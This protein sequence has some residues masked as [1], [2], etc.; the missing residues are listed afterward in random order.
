MNRLLYL[1]LY[2]I[3][4]LPFPFLY[5]LSDCLY[6]LLYYIPHYLKKIVC[7]NLEN[8]F[9]LHSPSELKTIEQEFYH[10]FCNVLFE[11][12]KP[13][14]IS[15]K[16]ILKRFKIKNPEVL[17]AFYLENRSMMLYTT[18]IGN[19]EWLSFIPHYTRFA[20]LT[21]YQPLSNKYINKLMYHIQSQF[22]NYCITSQQGYKELLR[23]KMKEYFHSI[24]LL[25]IRV[26]GRI[27]NDTPLL[28]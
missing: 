3:S 26:P 8:S 6:L 23:F 20:T 24:V 16:N 14:T 17:E 7:I 5:F 27:H 2:F 1:P 21:F 9:P 13:L 18:Q 11:A 15:K 25:G 4:I 22:G 28:L 12:I 19:W 10:H